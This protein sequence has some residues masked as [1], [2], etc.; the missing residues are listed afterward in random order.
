MNCPE[1]I[2]VLM[3]LRTHMEIQMSMINQTNEIQDDIL[4]NVDTLSPFIQ[5][6]TNRYK[7]VYNK[8]IAKE[9][10]QMLSLFLL[11]VDKE[12]KA[13]CMHDYCEDTIDT[14]PETSKK[15]TYCSHCMCT[16]PTD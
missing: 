11:E 1:N 3:K 7:R 4:S 14:G 9:E 6:F 5:S 13:T 16:F 12:L 8:D 2:E 10:E 15:I